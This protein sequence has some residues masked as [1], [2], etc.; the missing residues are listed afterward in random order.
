M[1]E[2]KSNSPFF[3]SHLWLTSALGAVVLEKSLKA[4]RQINSSTCPQRP[5]ITGFKQKKD[6]LKDEPR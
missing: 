3:H 1:R 2:K 5:D 4:Q 6:R